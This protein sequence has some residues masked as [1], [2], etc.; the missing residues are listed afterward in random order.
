MVSQSQLAK[1]GPE[2]GV[3]PTTET[4]TNS[5]GK[6]QGDKKETVSLSPAASLIPATDIA[7]GVAKDR[8]PELPPLPIDVAAP[9]P[10]IRPRVNESTVPDA[11]QAPQ[12]RTQ[13]ALSALLQPEPALTIVIRQSDPATVPAAVSFGN[14]VSPE[15]P[16]PRAPVSDVDQSSEHSGD[17]IVSAPNTGTS[18]LAAAYAQPMSTGSP[19]QGIESER[20]K[21]VPGPSGDGSDADVVRIPATQ[22]GAFQDLQIKAE[23]AKTSDSAAPRKDAPHA[24]AAAPEPPSTEKNAAQPIRSVALE[25]SPDGARD[26]RVRLAERAGEVHVSLHSNDPSITKSLRDGVTDLASLLAH[27][28]FEAKTWTSG[29]Q[30]Q[31][32]RQQPAQQLP[33]RRTSAIAGAVAFDGVL[34]DDILQQPNQEVS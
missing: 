26:V 4:A 17:A 31:E 22:T 32:H 19:V 14:A 34:Q 29:R 20:K 16:A 28:G 13:P 5:P 10:I 25:F 27:A 11:P 15:A 18:P 9:L 8:H 21:A 12:L 6:A 23:P 24:P 1:T 3:P 2:S 30:Q 7:G 33:Q